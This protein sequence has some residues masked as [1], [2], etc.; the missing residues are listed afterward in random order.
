MKVWQNLKSKPW[1]ANVLACVGAI[2]FA[3]QTWFYIHF[4][5]SILDEGNYLVKGLLFVRGQLTLYQDYGPWSNHMPLSFIIPGTVLNWFGP[6]LRTGRYLA[7]VLALLMLLGF[8]IVAR[9]WGKNWWAAFAVWALALN[10]AGLKIH[11]T[12][13][14]QVL[15][16]CMLVWVLVLVLAEERSLWQLLLGSALAGLILLTRE[17]MIIL[18]PIL[19][20]Y[21]WWQFGW[22]RALWS[23]LAMGLVI[24]IGFARYWP[25][26]L[27]VWAA[28]LPVDLLPFLKAY[29]A[30]EGISLWDPRVDLAGR[31]LSFFSAFRYHFVAMVGVLATLLLWPRQ[32]DWR[33]DY[34][35]RAAVFLL[36]TFVVMFFAHAW[37]TIGFSF[38]TNEAYSSSYCVFCF[39]VYL[40]FFSF[41]GILLIVIA[42]PSWRRTLPKWH[43]AL[44]AVFVLA[45]TTG[46]GFS[47]FETLGAPGCFLGL[48]G[49]SAS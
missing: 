35:F 34:H 5:D 20:L 18:L 39:P 6:S 19:L 26:I 40:G 10:P 7:F 23:A 21:L 33:S 3:A 22:R 28:W 29:Q 16:A 48:V 25:G 27:K 36:V 1:V 30:P 44:I 37:V 49:L 24:M 15:V 46:V 42:A 12:M 2:V 9:R 17:N 13:T 31:L 41:L 45:L 8:W 14:S 32:K 4:Q 47:V 11:S 43:Q 38:D